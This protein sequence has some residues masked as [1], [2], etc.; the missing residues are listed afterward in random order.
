LVDDDK[1]AMS[2]WADLE[3]VQSWRG[4]LNDPAIYLRYLL[5]D[6]DL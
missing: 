5:Q 6:G 3:I 4:F 1:S 2:R